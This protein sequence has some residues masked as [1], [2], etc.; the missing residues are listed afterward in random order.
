MD[1]LR[2][3]QV[4]AEVARSQSFVRAAWK[5]SVSKATV[6]KNVAWLENSMGSQLLNR[7]SKQ[8]TLTDAGLR[9]LESAQELLDRY[10]RL[11]ADVRDSVHLPR[12]SIR[13]GT[14]PAFGIH[15]LMPVVSGFGERYPDIET[16]VVLDDGRMDLL[17]EGLDLS[18][19]IAPQL[20][21]AAYI[22]IPLMK[23]PQVLV[24]SPA[25]LAR[26]GL[27]KD[28]QDLKRHN[29]LVHTLKSSAGYWRFEGSPR[30]EVR[31]RGTVRSN[32]GEALKMSALWGAGIALHPYYMVSNELSSGALQVVLPEFIPEE[33]DIYVVFSTRRNMPVRV[34]ALLEFLKAW[35]AKPPPWA[36]AQAALAPA[37]ARPASARRKAPVKR[38]SSL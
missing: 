14:P 15:H 18:I 8:V 29:C 9:V 26:A 22:A 25:Y 32:I 6:T 36:L 1:R 24:A 20:Q 12:G 37:A 4:F 33:L 7:S 34:R 31:V 11:E 30:Q 19:R 23:A 27:P 16:T 5:L 21:D 35:A 28:I 38:A 3:L 10:E 2:C 13:V 17:A